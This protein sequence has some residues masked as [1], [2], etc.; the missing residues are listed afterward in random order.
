MM[1]NDEAHNLVY[2]S[3]HG[4]IT[5]IESSRAY[6]FT[7]TA[8]NNPSIF[9]R[10]MNNVEVYGEFIYQLLPKQAIDM[11]LMVR[12]CI[13]FIK[14]D[15]VYTSADYDNSLNSIIY[16]SF[17]EHK[18]QFES[19]VND[20]NALK[21]T[22]LITLKL[23]QKDKLVKKLKVQQTEDLEEKSETYNKNLE[24]LKKAQKEDEKEYKDT[25][26]ELKEEIQ[27]VK[28]SKTTEQAL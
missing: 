3:F 8:Q 16:N 10:G 20:D 2:E 5:N 6:F 25:I 17:N 28:D 14:T 22:E 18:K 7:A 23:D 24:L 9:S 11:G 26:K 27:K 1:L 19:Y 21:S 15:N 4:V 12:P 13:H